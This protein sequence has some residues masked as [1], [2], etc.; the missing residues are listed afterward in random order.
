MNIKKYFTSSTVIVELNGDSKDEIL[1]EMVDVLCK[2]GKLSNKN[3]C[4]ALRALIKRE[5]M[6]STGI[7][8]GVAI[9]HAKT[10]SVKDLT[11][12]L[13]LKHEGIDFE[14]LDGKPS[15]IFIMTLS[16]E[17]RPVPHVQMLA[18]ISQRLSDKELRQKLLASKTKQ[19]VIKTFFDFKKKR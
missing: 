17:G 18:E 7:Q 15:K 5:R 2:A 9:P 6:M 16:P 10:N 3:S 12:V 14:A 19:D 8:D 1:K 11:A 13:G 4:E